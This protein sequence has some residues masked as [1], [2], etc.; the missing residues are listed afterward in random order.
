MTAAAATATASQQLSQSGKSPGPSRTGTKYPVQASLTSIW[1]LEA[2]RISSRIMESRLCH[3]VEDRS[4]RF[5]ERDI[6]SLG[7]MV[8]GSGQIGRV[9]GTS[10]PPPSVGNSIPKSIIFD[11]C[12]E[13]S[14]SGPSHQI[15][16]V[17]L[18]SNFPIFQMTAAVSQQLSHLARPL[19]HHAQG[20]NIPFGVNPSLRQ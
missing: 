3:L 16:L 11:I 15:R 4:E 2:W 20:P 14:S 5:L 18:V 7:V 17:E 6:W 10:P 13:I 9:L 12:S 8:Q 19:D 1:Y